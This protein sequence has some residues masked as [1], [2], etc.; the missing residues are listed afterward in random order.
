M[1]SEA[2]NE[3]PDAD[4]VFISCMMSPTM[5][6]LNTLEKEVR[7]PVI[8]SLSA[9]LYGIL[10]KLRIPDPVYPYGEALTRPRL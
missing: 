2:A 6:I 9:T 7:K 4:C 3:A 1:A 5:A 8:S 10:K